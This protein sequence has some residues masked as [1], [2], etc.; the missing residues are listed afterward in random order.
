VSSE[1]CIMPTHHCFDDA[2]DFITARVRADRSAVDKLT[3]VHG[4]AT[5]TSGPHLGE[6][7]AHAWVEEADLCWDAGIWRG[8]HLS[9]AVEHDEYYASLQVQTTTRYTVF[10]AYIQNKLWA[11]FGPWRDEY[12]N[13]CGKSGTIF[14]KVAVTTGQE[15]RAE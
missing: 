5:A 2:L 15:A 4:I 14:G 12:R 13:L 11:T 9:Y 10:E 6:P 1:E 3:L 8:Q 7:Y